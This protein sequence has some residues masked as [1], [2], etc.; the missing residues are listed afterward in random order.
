[1]ENKKTRFQKMQL[2]MCGALALDLFLFIVYLI[3]ASNGIVWL[4]VI[5]AIL[6]ILLS[7]LCLGFLYLSKEILRPRSLW[8]SVMAAAIAICIL[9]S[10]ILNF[11][12]PNPYS[13][14]EKEKTAQSLVDSNT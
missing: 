9:F 12:S 5:I 8:M 2:T 10:L 6:A 13:A 4:K 1:M 11:P 3:A 14:Y 7:L